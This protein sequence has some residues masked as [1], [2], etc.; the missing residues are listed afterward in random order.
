MNNNVMLNCRH[1]LE[2][3]SA[4]SSISS[5]A[6]RSLTA[7][8]NGVVQ[9]DVLVAGG[10]EHGEHVAPLEIVVV[11]DAEDRCYHHSLYLKNCYLID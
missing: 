9:R 11:V 1:C 2:S 3:S 8:G 6:R 10:D 5:I 4:W 7:D